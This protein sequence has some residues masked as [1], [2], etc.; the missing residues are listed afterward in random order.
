MSNVS[1]ALEDIFGVKGQV[2]LVTGGGTGIGRAIASGFACNG[3]KVYITGRRLDVLKK[4]A[5]EIGKLTRMGGEVIPLQGDVSTK[6]AVQTIAEAFGAKEE[7][8]DSL[9]NC[10]GISKPWRTEIKDH[11]DPEQ[12]LQAMQATEDEDW[13]ITNQ[14]NVNGVYYMTTF[15][16]PFLRKASHPSVVNIAS[17]AGLANQRAMG[18]LTYG[19]SKAATIHL[20]DLLAGRLH[21]F[22][23]RVNTICPGIF[24]SEM[25]GSSGTTASDHEKMGHAAQKAALRSTV[26]R[27]GQPEEIAG[28]VML[29]CSRGGQFMDNALLTVDGGR[30]MGAGIND[31]IR[32]PEHTF[33]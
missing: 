32:M 8:L 19:V 13:E 10:A 31:G 2:V 33:T 7:R 3:A 17:I 1:F 24:P 9:I 22:K 29:L 18:S 25:T 20:G 28:P 12:V 27:A 30:L 16:I 5:E 14:I 6:A 11:N 21:P 26:G 15:M 4:T 23:I